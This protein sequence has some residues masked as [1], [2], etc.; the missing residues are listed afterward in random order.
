L[1]ETLVLFLAQG[2]NF[3]CTVHLIVI[4]GSV[5]IASKLWWEVGWKRQLAGHGVRWSCVGQRFFKG[6]NK[7]RW[8]KKMGRVPK[9]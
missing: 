9:K 1:Q 3:S 6:L 2:C 8:R 7:A 4:G 5:S